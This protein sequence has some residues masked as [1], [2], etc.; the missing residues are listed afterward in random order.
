MKIYNVDGR[1]LMCTGKMY[2]LKQKA[3]WVTSY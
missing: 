1:F 2:A 3:C